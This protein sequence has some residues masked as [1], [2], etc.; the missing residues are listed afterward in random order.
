MTASLSGDS[1]TRLANR[2]GMV[3]RGG[4]GPDVGRE[5]GFGAGLSQAAHGVDEGLQGTREA[6]RCEQVDLAIDYE[7][8][9]FACAREGARRPAKDGISGSRAGALR[10]E[11]EEFSLG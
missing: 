11:S 1:V 7:A 9:W 10:E 4:S 6:L 2:V 5:G 3:A 8:E